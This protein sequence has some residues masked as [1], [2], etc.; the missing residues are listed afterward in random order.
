MSG[1]LLLLLHIFQQK[2]HSALIIVAITAVASRE[3]PRLSA[4]GIYADAAVVGHGG[5]AAEVINRLGFDVSVFRKGL[6]G[7]LG[8]THN[9]HLLQGCTFDSER[10]KNILKFHHLMGVIGGNH[11]LFFH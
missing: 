3:N 5:Q 4:Q 7:L 9:A 1:T 8:I 6:A 11:K 10:G 2:I